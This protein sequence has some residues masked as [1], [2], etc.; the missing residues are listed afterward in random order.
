MALGLPQGLFLSISSSH[1]PSL[2]LD[3]WEGT[4]YLAASRSCAVPPITTHP[5]APRARVR[6]K[7]I[8]VSSW[9]ADPAQR[10]LALAC[11][12]RRDFVHVGLFLVSSTAPLWRCALECFSGP[13]H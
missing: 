2:S 4:A 5:S 11:P 8:V 6:N 3:W 10:A 9:I 7:R 12:P 13:Q 1:L